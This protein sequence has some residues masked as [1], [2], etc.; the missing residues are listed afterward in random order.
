MQNFFER[1]RIDPV[2]AIELINW[3]VLSGRARSPQ[4]LVS[5]LFVTGAKSSA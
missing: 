2:G 5:I 1:M 4:T 3:E